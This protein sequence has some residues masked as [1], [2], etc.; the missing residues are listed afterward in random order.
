[1]ARAYSSD[2]RVYDNIF[3][4]LFRIVGHDRWDVDPDCS[5]SSNSKLVDEN[6]LGWRFSQTSKTTFVHSPHQ[7]AELL[8]RAEV[9]ARRG[10]SY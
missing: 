8:Q 4:L 2:F 10:T 9:I 5:E 3:G 7:P 6:R 1:M